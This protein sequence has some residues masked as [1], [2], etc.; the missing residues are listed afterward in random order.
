MAYTSEVMD[1]KNPTTASNY[2]V[3]EDAAARGRASMHMVQNVL[4]I[5]LDRNI[6]EDHNDDCRS[7]IKQLRCVVNN[8]NTFSD[9]NE[10]IDFLS[11]IDN[12]KACMIISGSLGERIVPL[13]HDM[14]QVDSIFIFCSYTSD[15]QE[16]TEKWPKINGIFSK[17]SSICE[18]LKEAVRQCEQNAI[19]ISFVPTG[20]DTL[21]KDLNQLDP[22]FM[23]TQILKEILLTI[24]FDE[25]RFEEFI[26]Y[27]REQF[28]VNGRELNNIQKFERT[29]H[30]E[31]PIRWYTCESFL[32]PMLNHVLRIMDMSVI[33][34]MG[35]F[36]SDLHRHIEELHKQQ[37]SGENSGHCF[38]VYR[39]QGLSIT[40]FEKMKNTK[41]GLMSFNNFLSTSKKRDVSLRFTR[42]ALLNPDL[43][44]ILFVM[45]V[46][47]SISS[48]LFAA[49]SDISTIQREDEVL[50]SMHTVFRIRDVKQMDEN[51]RLWQI[52][53]TLT[54]DNDPELHVLT[55][56][57]REET[58]PNARGWYRL[59]SLLLKMGQPDKAQQVYEVLIEQTS[60]DREKA[61][62]YCLLGWIKYD[63]GENEEAIKFYEKS[64][65]IF[66][67]TLPPN[68]PDLATA[69]NTI[70][71]VYEN[72]GD[73][74][75][76]ISSQEN[77][78]AIQQ[79]VLP[80]NHR[81]LAISYNNIGNVYSKV[82]NYPKALS[83]YEK[84][85][86]I[87]EKAIPPNSRG[88]TATCYNIGEVYDN[89]GDYPKALLYYEKTLEI[90]QETLPSNHPYLAASY[91]NIGVI[92]KHMGDYSK[93]VSL[94]ERA[95][96][97]GQR[98]L[99]TNHPNLK[100]YRNNLEIAKSKLRRSEILR[101]SESNRI[102][103][104]LKRD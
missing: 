104:T 88:V 62:I 89:I 73:Y 78:L 53:L 16:W 49:I 15:H 65:G 21:K 93:A 25:K 38:I 9:E 67:K 83:Y 28:A 101:V 92:Y 50:F 102:S 48:A 10:C 5:W 33:I 57:M 4:L 27:C 55:D 76:A 66:K 64:I 17:I 82:R 40:D 39:G 70:G 103:P 100:K 22:S 41:G 24:K 68:H 69:Y 31:T 58:F 51:T 77:A 98:S 47:P 72:T 11:E 32:Y 35:F 1:K 19:S 30:A 8:I 2:I 86:E 59:A 43:V 81:D 85:L 14:S 20:G 7:T 42:R 46:D 18:A 97:S 23:Y 71:M 80:S 34:K 95:V 26:V 44:G 37:F 60:T 13:V 90:R 36:V 6:D 29:Y 74:L 52:D 56:R 63:L 54:S 99:P 79:R 3:G 75:K 12:Q 84:A 96:E 94:Y 91:N 61:P 87:D 45:T